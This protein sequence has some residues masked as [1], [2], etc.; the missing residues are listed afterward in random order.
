MQER[1]ALALEGNGI[2]VPYGGLAGD[3]GSYRGSL[4]RVD[5][6]NPSG[7]LFSYTVPT[8][9]E[10]GMWTPPGPSVDAKGY[11]YQA[12]GNGES[13]SS[14][15]FS[16]S[17]TKLDGFGNWTD[18]YSPSTWADDNAKDL[19]LGSQGVALVGSRGSSLAGKRGTAYVLRQ[20]SS[21]TSAGR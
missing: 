1:G 5:K 15:D 7:S 21:V 20:S 13:A 11:L 9:R 19:D 12:A 4:V 2:W 6:T 3:C 10:A 8:T 16:D 18:Y 17:V 14:Y